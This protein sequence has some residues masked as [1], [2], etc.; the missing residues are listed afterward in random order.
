MAEVIKNHGRVS[1]VPEGDWENKK[2]NALSLVRHPNTGK[3][4]ISKK[5][6]PVDIDVD[7]TE[8][9]M[10]LLE[11]SATITVDSEFSSTSENP[12]QNKVIYNMLAGIE[13]ALDNILGE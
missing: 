10:F 7:N 4:Y 1:I 13:T 3:V 5:P 9:W 11:G 12:V 2:Y 8:Y 6:V